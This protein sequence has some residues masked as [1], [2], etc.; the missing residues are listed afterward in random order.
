MSVEFGCEYNHDGPG[1]CPDA[2]FDA[3][4]Y[5][6]WGSFAYVRVFVRMPRDSYLLGSYV[7]ISKERIQCKISCHGRNYEEC[8]LL[9]CR[10]PVRT[11]QETHYVS[12]TESSPL[13]Q[14]NIS[15]FH[16]VDYEESRLL[17]YRNPVRTPQET[18]RFHYSAQRLMLYKIEVFT[19][20]TMKNAFFWDV[21]TQF[22]LHKKLIT[23]LLQSPVR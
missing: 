10:N 19:A 23:F 4:G 12:A 22:V 1:S 6:V 7:A 9:G 11:S 13:M 20:V 8:R 5:C 14:C 3:G 18:L 21:E 16:G 15:V 17:G 2:K